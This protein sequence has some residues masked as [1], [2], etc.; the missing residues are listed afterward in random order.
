MFVIV[1]KDQDLFAII[2]NEC[3]GKIVV[4]DESASDFSRIYGGLGEIYHQEDCPPNPF[5][6]A[7]WHQVFTNPDL[8]PKGTKNVFI[9]ASQDSML[10]YRSI[11][12]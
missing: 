7:N 8:L 5:F 1:Q 4:G 9:D 10:D 2:E 3:R 11:A 6:L 12:A